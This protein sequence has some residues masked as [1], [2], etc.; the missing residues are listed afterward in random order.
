MT[1]ITELEKATLLGIAKNE[2]G[3]WIPAHTSER[4]TDS[5]EIRISTTMWCKP[6]KG[7]NSRG[8]EEHKITKPDWFTG[9]A[10]SW[11]GVLGS[12]IKKAL[13]DLDMYGND[14]CPYD[15]I[16]HLE[17][18]QQAIKILTDNGINESDFDCDY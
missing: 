7:Y 14:G 11:A 12:L 6:L 3:F 16:A 9:S 5:E 15:A 10:N 2:G 13:I 8:I 18:S 4:P 1:Q 17:F